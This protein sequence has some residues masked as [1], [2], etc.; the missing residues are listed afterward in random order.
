MMCSSSFCFR[1]SDIGRVLGLP[2]LAVVGLTVLCSRSRSLTLSR[3]SSTGLSPVS[4]FSVSLVDRTYPAS[5][6]SILIFSLV[7][8]A[9]F[10]AGSL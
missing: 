6:M 5:A 9:M 4:I 3:I 1:L 2:C 7:G 10:F 8:S